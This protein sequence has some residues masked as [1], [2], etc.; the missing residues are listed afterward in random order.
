[1]YVIVSDRLKPHAETAQAAIFFLLSE[2]DNVVETSGSVCF[3]GNA[4]SLDC[5]FYF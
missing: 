1:M 4:Y 3:P 5:Y 2:N